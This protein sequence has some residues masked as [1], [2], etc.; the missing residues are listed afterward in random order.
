MP[1]LTLGFIT[2]KEMLMG[3]G[4]AQDLAEVILVNAEVAM[5]SAK[6]CLVTE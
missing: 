6:R 3:S 2:G 5:V 1:V 4:N